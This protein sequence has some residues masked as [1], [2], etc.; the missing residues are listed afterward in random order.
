MYCVKRTRWDNRTYADRRK[1]KRLIYRALLKTM[2]IFLSYG[3]DTNAPLIEKIREYLSSGKEGHSKHDVWIDTSEIKAGQDWRLGI[4][5]GIRQSDIVLAGL[6]K[7][8]TSNPGVCR[9]EINISV[10]VM[11]GNIKTILL[12]PA[13]IVA[14]P[15]MLSHI[16]WLDMSDWKGHEE[17]GFESE[18]FNTKFE[19][20][21]RMIETPEN[22]R[23]NGDINLLKEKLH[24][25]SSLARIQSLTQKQMYGREWLY[26]KIEEWDKQNEQRI[27]W[28]VGGPGFG[29]STFA[30]NL[31][32]TYN[33]NIPAIQFV[34]WGKP[35]H[36]NPCA[37]LRNL[38]FQ[39]AIRYHD[40]M[41]QLLDLPQLDNLINMNEHELFDI[42]FCESMFL[43]IDGGHEN[44]WVLIDAL[45]EANDRDGNRIA[46]TIA[47]HVDRLP[48]WMKFILTSRDDYKVR[49]PLQKYHPQVF[50][51]S[52]ST[53]ELNEMDMMEFVSSEL[54]EFQPS[55]EQCK[56]IVKRSE[57]VFLFLQLVVDD[58]KKGIYSI[59]DLT[60]IPKDIS[61]YYIQFFTRAFL[62]NMSFYDEYVAKVLEI[63]VSSSK[64]MKVSLL[65]EC[66]NIESD[67]MFYKIIDSLQHFIRFQ[68]GEIKFFHISLQNWLVDHEQSGCFFIS[69]H[70]GKI[71]IC[72]TFVKWL[73]ASDTMYDE[74]WKEYHYGFDD[75]NNNNIPLPAHCSPSHINVIFDMLCPQNS[76][77]FGAIVKYCYENLGNMQ[78]YMDSLIVS[79]QNDETFLVAFF[80]SVFELIKDLY[81]EI[82]I[83][84]PVTR[85]FEWPESEVYRPQGWLIH[86]TIKKSAFFCSMVEY[87]IHKGC[88]KIM[89]SNLISLVEILVF[90][91]N[92]LG[93]ILLGK[94]ASLSDMADFTASEMERRIEKYK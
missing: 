50:D 23:F 13:D 61:S 90:Y 12:E 15:A 7:H 1:I 62:D 52:Q 86:D 85:S 28:I 21:S 6:S 5:E 88:S 42:L 4:S 69:P 87:M 33:A 76:Y 44:V 49:L 10:G 25:I 77:G 38:A 89:K 14:A 92:R 66:A 93:E 91:N 65:R 11:G 3:H 24:P 34:E 83:V 57:G 73:S 47:R 59:N 37:I 19:E 22:E 46:Q 36:S 55:L 35:D 20:L 40:Y 68:D 39:L 26:N 53:K 75:C 71:R 74:M 43:R 17:E 56:D 58:I 60:I 51:L 9:N 31:Q 79:Q 82:G 64:I 94:I 54:A 81:I 78:D 80:N 48:K 63:M 29:K 70:E 30:A 27:F 41:R 16:Q 18:Y 32:Q 72:N 45:D 2:K 84:S 8:S 67:R